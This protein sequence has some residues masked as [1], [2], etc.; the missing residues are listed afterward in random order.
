MAKQRSDAKNALVSI[1][2]KI[3]LKTFLVAVDLIWGH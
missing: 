3:H 1:I 2:T